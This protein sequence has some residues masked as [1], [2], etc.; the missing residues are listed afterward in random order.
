M[1]GGPAPLGWMKGWNPSGLPSRRGGPA[2]RP[3][4]GRGRL[5]ASLGARGARSGR[6]MG[7][8][9]SAYLLE[10]DG[11]FYAGAARDRWRRYERHAAGCGSRHLGP[12]PAKELCARPCATW[13]QALIEEVILAVSCWAVP[14]RRQGTR[15]GP[16]PSRIFPRE[17]E[18]VDLLVAQYAEGE[19]VLRAVL[20]ALQQGGLADARRR[21]LA[22]TYAHLA[23]ICSRCK[24]HGH[25][26]DACPRF[27]RQ[28][29]SA[30]T[31]LNSIMP[32]AVSIWL[33]GGRKLPLSSELPAARVRKRP[34]AAPSVLPPTKRAKLRAFLASIFSTHSPGPSPPAIGPGPS[35]D[36]A[37]PSPAA[38]AGPAS[39]PSG[40]APTIGTEVT[41]GRHAAR[42]RGKGK[43]VLKPRLSGAER[44]KAQKGAGASKE[45]LDRLKWGRWWSQADH[46]MIHNA[47]HN[48]SHNPIWN[49]SEAK[50]AKDRE[51]RAR[52]G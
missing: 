35:D 7:A 13:P 12:G 26:R 39:S 14:E 36:S 22:K 50:K 10:K 4:R 5:W 6:S 11:K 51:R 9:P 31:W 48:A 45:K 15:G 47:S 1:G 32:S 40:Q 28:Q 18:E 20:V 8:V 43:K 16:L 25:Y 24:Q 29:P 52:P 19:D 49:K 2:Y 38:A 42:K 44:R 3:G 37:P 46:N 21:G 17:W 34:A 33:E 30:T 41:T 23:D 27:H